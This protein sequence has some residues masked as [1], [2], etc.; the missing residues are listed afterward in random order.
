MKILFLTQ[1]F[2]PEPSFLGVSFVNELQRRGH[3]VQVL[4][5]FPNYPGGKVYDGYKV[6]LYQ[7]EVQGGVPILRVA[8]YPSHDK[9][10]AKRMANYLSFALSASLIGMPLI[11]QADVVYAYH[12]PGTIALPAAMRRLF[13]RT[14]IVYNIQDLWPDTLSASGMF[15]SSL[16]YKLVDKLCRWTYAMSDR[17]IVLSPGFK[18]TLMKRGV[19]PEKIDV[20]YN[21]CLDT[22]KPAP[23]RDEAAAQSLGMCG[24]FNIVFA[25]TMGQ[26]QALD[27]VL[28]AAAL[29]KSR[30]PSAHFHFVGSGVDVE[31]LKQIVVDKALSNVTFHPRVPADEIG[32]ILN[33]ADALLVHLKDDPLFTITIPSKIQ[34]Y[35]A[36]G[37][38]ILLGV[39]G[40]AAELIERSQSGL[41]CEPEDPQSIAEVVLKLQSLSEEERQAMGRNGRTFY[42][43][44]LA[45]TIG[46]EKIEKVLLEVVQARASRKSR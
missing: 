27:A 19:P 20:V 13:K 15:H 41:L 12:P 44:E 37:R 21:W 2:D 3:E 6:R 1:W 23:S 33:L 40:D 16:G 42:E 14:P 22:I 34:A 28:E 36:V 45:L 9:S 4:T 24:R 35:L 7:R 10:S 17:L 11:R 30:S 46:V 8:L 5:G 18:E 38:P 43:R 32:K 29:L 26:A 39:R 25:G 31:R